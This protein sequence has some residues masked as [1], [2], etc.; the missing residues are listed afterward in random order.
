[1]GWNS[2]EMA[3]VSNTCEVTGTPLR[4]NPCVSAVSDQQNEHRGPSLAGV[5]LLWAETLLL[6]GPASLWQFFAFQNP[7]NPFLPEYP[8]AS[9]QSHF[10]SF[11][12][13][14][15]AHVELLTR[16]PAR[17]ERNQVLPHS[18][19]PVLFPIIYCFVLIL[20]LLSSLT[21]GMPGKTGHHDFDLKI[22]VKGGG[23]QGLFPQTIYN[24]EWFKK[25]ATATKILRTFNQ[26][27]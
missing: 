20:Y 12:F 25:K 27:S 4:P 8:G 17:R 14:P 6:P 24:W 2:Q 3:E 23:S 10:P 9:A 1:M 18:K 19:S 22:K 21:Q 15:G 13:P 7:M 5:S 26:G 11:S 16:S